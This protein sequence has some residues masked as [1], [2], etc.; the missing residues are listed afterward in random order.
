MEIFSY[1]FENYEIVIL[2]AYVE[3]NDI[4]FEE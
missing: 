2:R 1:S 4:F 3:N